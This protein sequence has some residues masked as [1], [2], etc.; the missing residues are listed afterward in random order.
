MDEICVR[1]KLGNK[2]EVFHKELDGLVFRPALQVSM[3]VTACRAQ[4]FAGD[5]Q[6]VKR[7]FEEEYAN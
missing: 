6:K 2:I 3:V 1:N 7:L 5:E 4:C